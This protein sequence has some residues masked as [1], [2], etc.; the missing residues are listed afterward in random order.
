MP[1]KTTILL[2]TLPA[3]CALWACSDTGSSELVTPSASQSNAVKSKI[4]PTKATTKTLTP[5]EKGAKL[6]KRCKACHTLDDGGRHRVG[7][8]LWNIYGAK[9]GSKEGFAYSKAMSQSEIIWDES[10][11]DGYIAKPRDFMPGNRMSFVGIKR[12]EDR[13]AIQLY[14]KAQTTPQSP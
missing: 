5:M 8:N 14:L 4:T 3:I 11:I 1:R 13:D 9:A 10:S 7:P 6:Y 12:Q 2:I